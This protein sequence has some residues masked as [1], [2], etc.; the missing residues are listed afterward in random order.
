MRQLDSA[1]ARKLLEGL[2]VIAVY[3]ADG[4]DAEVAAAIAMLRN[5]AALFRSMEIE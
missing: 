4:D 5:I 1:R 2:A 3:A